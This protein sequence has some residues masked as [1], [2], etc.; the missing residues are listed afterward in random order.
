MNEDNTTSSV[1]TSV[2]LESTEVRHKHRR[3]VV[4][5]SLVVVAALVVYSYI[6]KK[7]MTQSP[8][9]V[10]RLLRSVSAPVTSTVEEQEAMIDVLQQG[11]PT[12]L[13]L[14]LVER[15]SA[16]NQLRQ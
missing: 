16:L 8:E 13:E 3:V 4:V 9:E 7:G 10:E 15:E 11:R 12:Q 5:V 14:P 6:Y 1:H 2:S